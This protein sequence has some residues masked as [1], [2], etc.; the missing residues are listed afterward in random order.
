M[1]ADGGIFR[2]DARLPRQVAELAIFQIHDPRRIRYSTSSTDGPV[3]PF[4]DA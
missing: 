1:Y 4:P 3:R 2:R